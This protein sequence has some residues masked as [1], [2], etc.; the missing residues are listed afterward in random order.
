MSWSFAKRIMTEGDKYGDNM[1]DFVKGIGDPEYWKQRPGLAATTATTAGIS[2]GAGLAG[3]YSTFRPED[4]TAQTIGE[5]ANYINPIADSAGEFVLNKYGFGM[6]NTE[7][8]YRAGMSGAG[9]LGGQYL[10]RKFLPTDEEGNQNQI[11]VYVAGLAGEAITDQVAEMSY[12]RL[13][14]AIRNNEETLSKLR[15]G[16][17][18]KW[19]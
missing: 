16:Q 17:L 1:D 19:V 3:L 11:G 8:G 13:A 12:E 4:E 6:N 9:Q 14:N 18:A 10:A 7:S 2:V 15:L 5:W